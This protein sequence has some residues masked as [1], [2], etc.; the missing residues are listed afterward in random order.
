[1][2]RI[3]GV[4]LIGFILMIV[5]T[6]FPLTSFASSF[7]VSRA[8]AYMKSSFTC[9]CSIEGTGA[10]TGRY[11]LI[12]AAHN[13]Y[14]QYHGEPLKECDFYFGAKTINN[15]FYA[16]S[17]GFSYTVYDTFENGYRS[18]NDIGYVVFNSPVG[19]ITGWFGTAYGYCPNP[20]DTDVRN[21]SKEGHLQGIKQYFDFE[22]EYIS[23]NQIRW[24]GVF[25]H[26]AMGGPVYYW[27]KGEE[28]PRVIAVTT[29][30]ISEYSYG[31]LLTSDVFSDMKKA[32]AIE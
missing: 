28:Y 24:N 23:S 20:D 9:G 31:R 21:Y 17:G 12:T 22:I 25:A 29:S 7:D 8:T 32:G 15:Y 18:E 11:G 6:V 16:Y 30:A 26:H 3:I 1:M 13:L 5:M 2:K 19:D 4:T 27:K 10:M 14:C